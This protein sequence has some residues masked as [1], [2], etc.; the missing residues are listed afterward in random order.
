MPPLAA[1]SDV[2]TL[3]EMF[4]LS[5]AHAVK[6]LYVANYSLVNAIDLYDPDFS[7][8]GPPP[9]PPMEPPAAAADEPAPPPPTPPPPPPPP[10]LSFFF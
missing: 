9:D 8:D 1:P 3:R 7:F 4:N 2:A 10:Q 6:L 5:P